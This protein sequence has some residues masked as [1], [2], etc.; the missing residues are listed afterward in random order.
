MTSCVEEGSIQHELTHA[1]GFF[2]QQNHPN[3]D[4]YVTIK[5]INI[6]FDVEYSFRILD[7]IEGTSFNTPYDFD[8]IM[9]YPSNVFAKTGT[10]TIV[11]NDGVNGG[12]IAEN[13]NLSVGD[14][15]RIRRMYKCEESTDKDDVAETTYRTTD[16]D[17]KSKDGAH[18]TTE[19]I[20]D[21]EIEDGVLQIYPILA[22][23]VFILV[24]MASIAIVYF[25][26]VP[27][28][29]RDPYKIAKMQSIKPRKKN[30]YHQNLLVSSE[31]EEI[32]YYV[33]D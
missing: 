30:D 14:I 11:R 3:R 16:E 18:E 20:K 26:V 29:T 22:I 10:L 1:L 25:Y 24:V 33:S 6:A 32:K 13:K 5:S 9:H 27:L 19:D 21:K 23:V 15:T 12:N 28:L 7:S 8:F 4:Q 2:H 17:K 31:E